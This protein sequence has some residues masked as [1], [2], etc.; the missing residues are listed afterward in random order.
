MSL[1]SFNGIGISGLS[2]AVPANTIDNLGYQNGLF[3]KEAA[4][5]IVSKTGIFER[6]FA[7]P[8]MCA[9]DLCFAAAEKLLADL[10]IDRSEIDLV[11]FIS[12]TPDYRMPATSVLLQN[13]L[14]LSKQTAAFDVN[15]G[16][17]AFVYGLSIAFS[18]L[19]QGGFRKVL[20]LD[21]ET[22]SRVYS[23]NDRKVA[24]LFGDGGVAAVLERNKKFGDS[25]F[26]LNS[27]G[28]RENLIK[29]DAGGYRKPSSVDTVASRMVDDFGN[30][31]S[32]EHGYMNGADVFNFV[33][34]EIPK[35]LRR[36]SEYAE[37]DLHS[38][39]YYIFH[40]ANSY[41]NNYLVKKLKI[42]VH[43]VPTSLERFGNTSS[44]SIPLT[45]VDKL[46]LQLRES[47]NV[48]LCGFGVG[49]SWASAILEM[50]DCQISDMVEL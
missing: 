31:R 21:G 14:G 33:I 28:S 7:P 17:S 36:L 30:V 5:D 11:L 12:Q 16:C 35:D 42:P 43:K 20:L 15:L 47:N 37:T 38:L 9:S 50:R 27:D 48:L 34:D 32:E 46:K 29:I 25:Y 24:Y 3:G 26:S 40:Q 4:H 22:R 18:F 45:I 8:G 19:Q 41:M 2:A 1:L 23:E 10:S 13:R 39:D 6:R 49:M 44:V